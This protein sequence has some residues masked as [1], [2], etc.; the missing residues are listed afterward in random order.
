MM[1]I[2]I[3]EFERLGI[4]CDRLYA[5][6]AD[7][8]ESLAVARREAAHAQAAIDRVLDACDAVE[9]QAVARPAIWVSDIRRALGVE[10][11]PNG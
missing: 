9:R 2:P 6:R 4:R 11:D 10:A 8:V 7:L 5:R 3:A 1:S